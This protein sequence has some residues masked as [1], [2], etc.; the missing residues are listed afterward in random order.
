M[1]GGRRCS[2]AT[3]PG[4]SFW[5]ILGCSMFCYGCMSSFVLFDSSF[6]VLRQEIGWEVSEMTYF[7]LQGTK[8]ELN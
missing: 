2:V 8:P 5:V 1:E 4:F 7:V 3:E 6:S